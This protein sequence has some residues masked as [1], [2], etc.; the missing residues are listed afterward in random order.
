[1]RAGAGPAGRWTT[2]SGRLESRWDCRTR[3]EIVRPDLGASTHVTA[4]R[5][6]R[7]TVGYRPLSPL[8]PLS[9]PVSPPH[10]RRPYTRDS[11]LPRRA[12]PSTTLAACVFHNGNGNGDRDGHDERQLT[13]DERQT[14]MM[15]DQRPTYPTLCYVTHYIRRSP[16]LDPSL[17]LGTPACCVFLRALFSLSLLLLLYAR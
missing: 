4:I 10:A 5:L 7:S 16:P 14:T 1:L 6:P 9:V 3:S 17:V 8:S 2:T 15:N 12:S 13:N 11:R